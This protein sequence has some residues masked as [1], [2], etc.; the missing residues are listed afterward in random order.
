MNEEK[1]DL[2]EIR[3]QNADKLEFLLSHPEEIN[4]LAKEQ[5]GERWK[6][7]YAG[8]HHYYNSQKKSKEAKEWKEEQFIEEN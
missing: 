2:N 8:E 3:K 5:Y 6:V 1:I 7:V 4:K